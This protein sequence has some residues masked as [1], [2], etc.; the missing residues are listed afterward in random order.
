MKQ[1]IEKTL[2][3]NL[4]PEFLEVKNNS[5]LHLGHEESNESGETHFKVLIKALDLKNI[6][7]LNAHRKVK[8]LLKNEFEKGLHA[9]E[10]KILN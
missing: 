1:R 4:N 2:I 10:I 8:S 3:E 5:Y 6:S 9:L 7:T